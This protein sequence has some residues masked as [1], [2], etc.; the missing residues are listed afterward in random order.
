MKVM[1]TLPG[2]GRASNGGKPPMCL[3]HYRRLKEGNLNLPI[4]N[5]RANRSGEC[6]FKGCGRIIAAAGLCSQHWKQRR[7]GKE[8]KDIR[9]KAPNGAGWMDG[10][11]YHRV[12]RKGSHRIAM[13]S[14]LGRL[15]FPYETV[16]HINGI[17]TDNRIENL[18]LWVKRQQPS[19]QRVIDRVND[20]V[21]ILKSYAPHL[22]KKNNRA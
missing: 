4:L 1:C 21:D 2:C 3:S 7:L 6:E 8:L 20:A 18:E 16:H 15:L 22:L 9:E 17:R 12:G 10:D 14:H 11:G 19:G 5:R 13:E